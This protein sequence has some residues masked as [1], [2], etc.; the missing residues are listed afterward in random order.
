MPLRETDCRSGPI[1]R[2]VKIQSREIR[3]LR[4]PKGQLAR[5]TKRS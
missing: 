5:C 1:T 3:V 2:P 4:E